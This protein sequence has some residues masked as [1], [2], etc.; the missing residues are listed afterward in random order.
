MAQ[1]GDGRAERAFSQRDQGGI[2][3]NWSELIDAVAA[4]YDGSDV[5]LKN[6]AEVVYGKGNPLVPKV[7]KQLKSDLKGP[8]V[9]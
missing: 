4:R 9:D 6:S 1:L 3:A 8:F 2:E 5:Q 7:V